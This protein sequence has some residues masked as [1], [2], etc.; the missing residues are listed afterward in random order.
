M[1][2]VP[3]NLCKK[4]A[5]SPVTIITLNVWEYLRSESFVYVFFWTLYF[6]FQL[7]FALVTLD[8][9]SLITISH[10]LSAVGSV[11]HF[12]FVGK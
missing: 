6:F 1:F 4:N 3:R 12:Y 10:R 11:Q 2:F 9:I 8:A 7:R 5:Y